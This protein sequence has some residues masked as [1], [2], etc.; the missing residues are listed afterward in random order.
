[1]SIVSDVFSQTVRNWNCSKETI[2]PRI[3]LIALLHINSVDSLMSVEWYNSRVY[4]EIINRIVYKINV[5]LTNDNINTL[6]K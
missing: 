4:N 5:F 2:N 6:N 3:K 1:M